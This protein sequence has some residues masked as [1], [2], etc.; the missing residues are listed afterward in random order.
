MWGMVKGTIGIF[1]SD[2]TGATWV[3]L[4]DDEH[5]YGWINVIIGDRACLAG[6]SWT[7][8]RGIIYGE[9]EPPPPVKHPTSKPAR[10]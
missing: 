9:P 10:R 7:A 2:D 3:R 8:G 5:Q 1:R 4:N 6:L